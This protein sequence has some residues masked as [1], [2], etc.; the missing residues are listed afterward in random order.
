MLW[1]MPLGVIPVT[2]R[3]C[4]SSRKRSPG[5]LTRTRPVERIR[6]SDGSGLL[7]SQLSIVNSDPYLLLYEIVSV[8]DAIVC[9]LKIVCKLVSRLIQRDVIRAGTIIMMTRPYSHCSIGFPTPISLDPDLKMSQSLSK[10][11]ATYFHPRTSRR[12]ARVA[13]ASPD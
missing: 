11:S 6:I 12:N 8:D 10:S 5:S 2:G 4:K 1:Y 7:S 13:L 9:V 3:A